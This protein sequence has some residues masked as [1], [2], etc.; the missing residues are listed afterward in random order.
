MIAVSFF[1]IQSVLTTPNTVFTAATCFYLYLLGDPSTALC[2]QR[3]A[4]PHPQE[5][6]LLHEIDYNC[7]TLI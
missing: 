7:N 3:Y 6:H 5:H 1:G 2:S 4:C